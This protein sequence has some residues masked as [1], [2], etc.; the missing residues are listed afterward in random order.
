MG[1]TEAERERR[2]SVASEA[3]SSWSAG[4]SSVRSWERTRRW[5]L[6]L[7]CAIASSQR[8]RGGN[9]VET[10]EEIGLARHRSTNN[11]SP[12]TFFTPTST[13]LPT[14]RQSQPSLQRFLLILPPS[15]IAP[16]TPTLVLLHP[17]EQFP[18]QKWWRG[19]LRP[20]RARN[21]N[22]RRRNRP[23]RIACAPAPTARRH[24]IPHHRRAEDHRVVL[25]FLGW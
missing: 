9:E 17:A 13:A 18:L 2:W 7:G 6:G 14:Q 12:S 23:H 25:W 10:Y 19:P 11:S 20:Q 8:E 24:L 22:R 4:P 15:P 16:T 5:D 21:R 1:R 3:I